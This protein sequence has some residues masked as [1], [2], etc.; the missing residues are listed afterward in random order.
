MLTDPTPAAPRSA[1]QRYPRRLLRG[2]RDGPNLVV[3]QGD[4][5]ALKSAELSAAVVAA[6][7]HSRSFVA[8]RHGTGT[9][10]LFAFG[11]PV[12]PRFGMGSASRHRIPAPS[13]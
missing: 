7:R 1:E 9:A 11:V 10:A 5:P 3:L 13:N 6:R 8:D 12:D 2:V 4:L